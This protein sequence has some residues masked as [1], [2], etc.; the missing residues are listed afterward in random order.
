MILV[1]D[2]IVDSIDGYNY[3]LREENTNKSYHLNIEF[4]G[5]EENASNI[6]KI[7]MHDN[8]LQEHQCLSFGPI[9]EKYGKTITSSDDTDFIV[10]VMKEKKRYYLKRFYG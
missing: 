1:K 3:Y 10:V 9:E 4:Y 8:L 2:L 5:L 7:Y 6:I